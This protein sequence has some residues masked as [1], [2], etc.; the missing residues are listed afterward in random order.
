MI[1]L[2]PMNERYLEQVL[3]LSIAEEQLPYVGTIEEVLL[4]ADS[5]VHPHLVIAQGNPVGIF[6]IDTTYCQQYD[7]AP[8]QA[9]GFRAFLIDQ[10]SQGKGYGSAVIAQLSDYLTQHYAAFRQV[11]LTVNCKNASAYRCYLN[12]GFIDSGELY[13][14]GAAGPQHIMLKSL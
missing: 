10:N 1:E 2:T 3:T 11:Y 9:L 5:N 13:L 7:F 6:L 12:N 14:G 4:N 8:K